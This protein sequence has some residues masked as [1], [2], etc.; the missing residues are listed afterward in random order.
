MHTALKNLFYLL[1]FLAAFAA[2][3]SSC[4]CQH[5]LLHSLECSFSVGERAS[6]I[7]LGQSKVQ[8]TYSSPPEVFFNNSKIAELKI[9]GD[10]QEIKLPINLIKKS[11][12]NEIMI[13]TGQNMF[14]QS[15]VDY[16]DIE[17][18]NLSIEVH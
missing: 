3:F 14:Q 10:H 5:V 18:M 17:L 4:F 9:N 6:K 7:D 2:A 11:E 13:K 12:N 15:Y 8:T 16:D 1:F